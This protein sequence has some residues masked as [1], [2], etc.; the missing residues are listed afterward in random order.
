LIVIDYE[1]THEVVSP[2]VLPCLGS[3]ADYLGRV[4]AQLLMDAGMTGEAQSLQ[5]VDIECQS[6]HLIFGSGGFDGHDMMHTSGTRH[7]TLL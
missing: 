1:F 3:L 4:A 6:L 5:I 2:S 7:D